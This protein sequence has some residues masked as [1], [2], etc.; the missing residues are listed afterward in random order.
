MKTNREFQKK[1]RQKRKEEGN[2]H[3][4]IRSFCD[5]KWKIKQRR[6]RSFFVEKE[7][8]QRRKKQRAWHRAEKI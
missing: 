8:K 4:K 1:K 2:K 6:K 5:Q 7:N 3:R